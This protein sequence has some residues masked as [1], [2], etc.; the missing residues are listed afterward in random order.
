MEENV[1]IEFIEMGKENGTDSNKTE[2]IIFSI[3]WFFVVNDNLRAVFV[4][5]DESIRSDFRRRSSIEQCIY[6]D[7]VDYNHDSIKCFKRDSK[8]VN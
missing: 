7:K 1:P 3:E 6:S 5:D 2:V 8:Q 4:G